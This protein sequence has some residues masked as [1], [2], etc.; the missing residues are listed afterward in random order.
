MSYVKSSHFYDTVPPGQVYYPGSWRAPFP[1]WGVRPVMAGPRRLSVGGLG[2]GEGFGYNITIGTPVGNQTISVPIEQMANDAGQMAI[3]AA[4]P[5]LKTK[6]EAELP[7][8]ISKLESQ[9]P[10]VFAAAS[11]EVVTNLWPQMQPKLRSEVDYA[12]GE[13][14]KTGFLVGGAVVGAILLSTLYLRKQIRTPR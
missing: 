9:L 2:G 8:I 1:G 4:W 14:K 12:L 7:T 10:T 13:A 11:K 6:I 3:N 5:P